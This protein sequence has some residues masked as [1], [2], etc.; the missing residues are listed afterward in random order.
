MPESYSEFFSRVTGNKPLPYQERLA[1]KPLSATLLIVPTGLGK[2]EAVFVPWLFARSQGDPEAPTRLA[3]VLPRRNLTGQTA[4]RIRDL[5]KAAGL[6]DK[7]EV[8]ELMG[9][10]GDNERP[11]LPHRAS[12]IV[13]TQDLF[14]SRA[15]NRGYARR[16]SRWPQDFALYNQDCMIVLDEV[17]LMDDALAT[18]TQLAAFRETFGTYGKAPCVWM[19]ATARPEW[20]RT[21]DFSDIPPVVGIDEDDRENPIVRQR[22]EAPKALAAAPESCGSPTGC[23]EF[24]LSQHRAGSRTLIIANTVHRAREIAGEIR[25]RFP[26]VILLHSRFRSA[27]RA[28]TEKLLEMLAAEGQIIVA[29]QVLE[30]GVDITASRLISDVAPWG[31]LVQR[32]GRVNR[33]GDDGSSEIWWVEHPTYS[34]QKDPVAPYSAA[35]IERAVERLRGLQSAAPQDLPGEDGP[36][37][38]RHVLRRSDLLDLFDTSSD[39]AGNELD[40]SRFI[41]ATDDKNVYLAWREWDGDEQPPPGINEVQ[42]WELCPVGIGEAREFAKKHATYTWNFADDAWAR[43]DPERLYPGMVLMTRSIEGGYTTL[44]G[45]SPVSKAKVNPCA[46]PN[47]AGMEGHSADETNFVARRQLLREHTDF[48]CEEMDA[49][50]ANEDLPEPVAASL[51]AAAAKHDWGKAHEVFQETMHRG[52]ER[53]DEL[54]GKRVGRATHARRHFRHELA[55]ALAMLATGESDLA[56]YLAAAHHGR[57]RMSIRSMP[58]ENDETLARGIYDGET[59]PAAEIATGVAVPE[60]TLSLAPM[61]FGAEGGSWT[62]RMLQLRDWLGPFRLAYLEM[63]LRAADGE[64]SAKGNLEADACTN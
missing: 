28:V 13:A 32:F 27:D 17:Q 6:K 19:S 56:T 59:L 25:K 10:S 51:R 18:S 39:L 44:D 30:A 40:V 62:E 55:S 20:L 16:P 3:F 52:S 63:L 47:G 12:V 57:I 64:A 15:L 58:G 48:V 5:V 34:K 50:L 49:L 33:Y 21:V 37:P 24:A 29:T 43:T 45:W 26:A 11:L 22:I 42:D 36:A 7:I 4:R 2:T 23:A 46:V 35:E 61:Q 14:F 60:V 54:L 38:W 41:R 53:T 9:G 31:S 8:L 1:A